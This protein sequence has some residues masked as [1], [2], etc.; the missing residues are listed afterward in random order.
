LDGTSTYK[1]KYF[2]QEVQKT[3]DVDNWT[4]VRGPRAYETSS[5]YDK[6]KQERAEEAT[7]K[8]VER[9]KA[10]DIPSQ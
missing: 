2:R 8:R 5:E 9:A 7:R 4:N 1:Y 6:V 3:V 10:K